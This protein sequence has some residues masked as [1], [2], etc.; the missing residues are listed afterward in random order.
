M[1]SLAELKVDSSFH[2]IPVYRIFGIERLFQLINERSLA[3][4]APRKWEDPYE[5]A[6][7]DMLE[8]K[9]NFRIFGLCWSSRS[10]SDAL[11]RIYSPNSLGVRVSSTL[12]RISDA[13][14]PNK[15]FSSEKFFVGSVSYIP[16][17]TA[18]I[19]D[20]GKAK[21][22]LQKKDFNRTIIT[23]ADAIQD[24]L[25]DKS[26]NAPRS[27]AEIAK[28]FLVKRF[29]FNHESE[30]RFIYVDR[31]QHQDKEKDGIYKI[32]I[33]PLKL[34]RTIQFDPRMDNDVFKA[35]RK[36]VIASLGTNKITIT[37]SD[38][39]KSPEKLL[40]KQK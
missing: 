2:N 34:I 28:T 30:V 5:K 18:N 40:S 9:S 24:M 12:G 38:L 7:Q 19:F 21:L 14:K 31:D 17:L 11:W 25:S 15:I 36:A 33:D 26:R 37:K 32:P 29:A 10:K 27:E 20:F 16:E 6:L 13:I 8:I 23:V 3:L 35:L 1:K 4:L 22:S 39:Y